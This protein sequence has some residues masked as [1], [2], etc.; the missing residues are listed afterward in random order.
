MPV[1]RSCALPI[2]A[3]T[4]LAALCAGGAVF[5]QPAAEVRLVRATGPIETPQQLS[6]GPVTVSVDASSNAIPTG[7][8]FR[9]V[10]TA[11]ATDR[12]DYLQMRMRLFMPDNRNLVYQKTFVEQS[13]EDTSVAATFER[14]IEDI[15][16]SPGAYPVE[17]SVRT[18][19]S[20]EITETVLPTKLLVFDPK[21]DP[22]RLSV[23]ARISAQPMVD[24]EGRFVVD[25]AQFTRARDEAAA[26]AQYALSEPTARIGLAASPMMLQ[27]W[28]RA[29]GGYRFVGPEGEVAIAATDAVPREYAATLA[30]LQ[31]AIGSGRLELLA[32]RLQRPGP[33]RAVR[34]RPQ[35]RCRDPVPV[36]SS[37]D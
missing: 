26:I 4:V 32:A 5:A 18:S 29:A 37:R 14:T 31:R 22:V 2:A 20:G 35:E 13:L 33:L 16:L 23:I 19:A 36:G 10:T 27:E 3:V 1:A 21:S 8:T 6:A 17:I 24:A 30:L 11:T 34:C 15:G 12:V 25:P 7:G 9:F 28:R